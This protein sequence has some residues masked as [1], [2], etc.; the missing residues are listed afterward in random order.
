MVSEMR[1]KKIMLYVPDILNSAL[2]ELVNN[3]I[4]GEKK[5]TILLKAIFAG[6]K[7]EY[8]VDLMKNKKGE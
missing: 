8:N 7:V 4:I 6:L 1:S 3:S 5:N 2:D